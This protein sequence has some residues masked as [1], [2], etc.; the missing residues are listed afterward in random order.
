[1]LPPHCPLRRAFRLLLG[2]TSLIATFISSQASACGACSCYLPFGV[3]PQNRGEVP[4]NARF[5]VAMSGMDE[6][7]EPEIVE[8]VYWLQADG[9]EVDFEFV[10]AEGSG[11]EEWLVPYGELPA[12]TE[13]RIE[14]VTDSVDSPEVIVF[15]TGSTV[16]T[17]PPEASAPTIE[18]IESSAACDPFHGARLVWPEIRDAG[19]PISYD[20][21]V[22]LHVD[23][24]ES[25]AVL[26]ANASSRSGTRSIDLAAPED[27]PGSGCWGHLGLP[28]GTA[29]DV[30]T[31]TATIY[32]AAGNGLELDPAE[33]T[34]AT[35]PGATCPGESGGGKC[36]ATAPGRDV[37]HGWLAVALGALALGAA[38]SISNQWRGRKRAA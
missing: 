3:R 9:T 21:V 38:R 16:D 33:V 11:N 13:F 29:G 15:R 7:G 23:L 35:S 37:R 8:S 36:A 24:G 12:N 31:V 25:T 19:N 22:R 10:P 27:A 20:P 5:L 18:V 17:T 1:M 2:A 4:L 34:L 6:A 32:D 26:F 30:V 28:F 14:T